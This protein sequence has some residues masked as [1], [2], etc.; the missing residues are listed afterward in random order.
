MRKPCNLAVERPFGSENWEPCGKPSVWS[1]EKGHN[2]HLCVEHYDEF[3][4][5]PREEWGPF[6]MEEQQ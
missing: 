1:N 6:R 5:V 3:A 4:L 2:M